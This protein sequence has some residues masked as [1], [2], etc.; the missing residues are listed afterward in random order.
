ME[1]QLTSRTRTMIYC[2]KWTSLRWWPL[3]E[4][5][6]IVRI[7]SGERA[8]RNAPGSGVDSVQYS[9]SLLIGGINCTEQNQVY[10]LMRMSARSCVVCEADVWKWRVCFQS[11]TKRAVWV[12]LWRPPALDTYLARARPQCG[13]SIGKVFMMRFKMFNFLDAGWRIVQDRVVVIL[14]ATLVRRK[15]DNVFMRSA[16]RV[17]GWWMWDTLNCC[18]ASLHDVKVCVLLVKISSSATQHPAHETAQND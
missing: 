12:P 4:K 2:W 10:E 6:S 5:S 17:L 11:R 15:W 9:N 1:N 14:V 18:D 7:F 13:L 16:S 8:S 3:Y